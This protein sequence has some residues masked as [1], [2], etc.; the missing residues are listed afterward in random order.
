MV[1][2]TFEEYL[3][4]LEDIESRL[5]VDVPTV[6]YVWKPNSITHEIGRDHDPKLQVLLLQILYIGEA[7]WSMW[8]AYLLPPMSMR[9]YNVVY[10]KNKNVVVTVISKFQFL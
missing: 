1:A 6:E 8:K 5:V 2:D 10:L 4:S 3:S 7:G 9:R